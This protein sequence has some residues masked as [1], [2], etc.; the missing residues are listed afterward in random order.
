MS[1]DPYLPGD[2]ILGLGQTAEPNTCGS[3]LFF[4]RRNFT[5]FYIKDE[6]VVRDAMRGGY[7]K[8]KF[9]PQVAM[10]QQEEGGPTNWVNDVD[11]CDLWRSSGKTFIVSQR[12]HP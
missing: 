8:F 1:N 4:G 12:I 11:R 9:P 10:R 2:I 5:E 7:C 6:N 3:C